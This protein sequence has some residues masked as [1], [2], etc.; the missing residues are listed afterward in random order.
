MVDRKQCH[1][2][3]ELH[4]PLLLWKTQ[5]S[6]ICPL[7]LHLAPSAR[8]R[9]GQVGCSSHLPDFSA[10]CHV[11]SAPTETLSQWLP[12]PP[13]PCFAATKGHRMAS[14]LEGFL[15]YSA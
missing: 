3:K 5:G 12:L 13:G 11:A 8:M 9:R 7:K 10:L 14:L 4:Q 1:V 15:F 6:H 2:L